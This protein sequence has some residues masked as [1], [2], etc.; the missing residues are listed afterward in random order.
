M[1]VKWAGVG[2]KPAEGPFKWG[3]TAE[4][5]VDRLTEANPGQERFPQGLNY[6]TTIAAGFYKARDI[7]GVWIWVKA[8]EMVQA[9]PEEAAAQKKMD[10]DRLAAEVERRKKLGL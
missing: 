7:D 1:E 8:G 10:A 6:A 5:R 3:G 2:E 9:T 4:A